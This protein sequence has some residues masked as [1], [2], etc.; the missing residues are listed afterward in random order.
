M[1]NKIEIE[2]YGGY[3]IEID[4]LNHTLK[5]RVPGK[6]KMRTLGYYKDLHQTLEYF[7]K[8][9]QQEYIGGLN[10]S[11]EAYVELVKQSNNKAVS[12][13]EEM[14]ESERECCGKSNA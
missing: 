3:F 4:N 8:Y 11:L 6:N 13:I 7:L 5:K 12:L 10:V 14:I 1:G 2:L 9:Y